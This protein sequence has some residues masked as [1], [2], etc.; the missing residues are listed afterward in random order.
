MVDLVSVVLE[1]DARS[2]V[3]RFVVFLCFLC[4]RLVSLLRHSYC[5]LWRKKSKFLEQ[6][7]NNELV[8]R[9]TRGVKKLLRLVLLLWLC[10]KSL[11]ERLNSTL[12]VLT[13]LPT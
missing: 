2:S 11:S 1:M 8:K 12:I 3:D 6:Y 13:S 10:V 9:K 4:P 5:N 7:L